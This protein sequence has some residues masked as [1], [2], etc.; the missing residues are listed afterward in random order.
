MNRPSFDRSWT[1]FLDRDGVINVRLMADYVKSSAEFELLPGVA[2]AIEKANSV[3]GKVVVV[4][5]QQGIGK[6]IMTERNLSD[7]HAYC[8]TLLADSNGK[9]DAYYFAPALSTENSELRKPNT[10]M[11]QLAKQQFPQIEF[12]KSVLIGD[13]DSDIEFGKRLGMY[14]VFIGEELH[15]SA[16]ETET[17]LY[18]WIKNI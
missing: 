15:A 13:S 2:Q 16:D 1:L 6:G 10:G 5:N 11:A 14:T 7:I 3:F 17:S 4:T 18:H 9:I 12:N 8:D